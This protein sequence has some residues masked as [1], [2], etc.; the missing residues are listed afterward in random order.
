MNDPT[1]NVCPYCAGSAK[2]KLEEEENDNWT[3][4]C[5][6]CHAIWGLGGGENMKHYFM[7]S[8]E[9]VQA[10][11]RAM[12]DREARASKQEDGTVILS[13]MFL[14]V[15]RPTANGNVYPP[16]L[17]EKMA[18]QLR[19]KG[20][21]YFSPMGPGAPQGL[22]EAV[23]HVE[24]A[25]V[26]NG[27]IRGTIKLIDTPKGKL[28]KEMLAMDHGEGPYRRAPTKLGFSITSYGEVGDDGVIKDA[29]PS[30]VDLVD[31]DLL[32]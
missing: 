8:G 31:K 16:E 9:E 19:D 1:K 24:D 17:A 11:A 27:A 12:D 21:T 14:P 23:G 10:L 6:D 15:G 22:S 3:A 4:T 2:I 25:T 18:Q 7:H 26:V 30:H 20:W 29:R 32:K 13:G 28:L 5:G